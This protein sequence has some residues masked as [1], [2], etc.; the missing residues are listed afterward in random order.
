[1]CV[2]V[3]REAAHC[4]T[5]SKVVEA[6]EVQCALAVAFLLP[7]GPREQLPHLLRL[8]RHVRPVHRDLVQHRVQLALVEPIERTLDVS[9]V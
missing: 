1:V 7:P 2:C 3:E 5:Q 4:E 8:R 6:K 9:C